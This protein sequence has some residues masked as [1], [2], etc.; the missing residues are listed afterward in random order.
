MENLKT[1]LWTWASLGRYIWN[2]KSSPQH[3]SIINFGRARCGLVAMQTRTQTPADY[4]LCIFPLSAET[5]EAQAST[6]EGYR[7]G[8]L[9]PAWTGVFHH[10]W[11]R[12]GQFAFWMHSHMRWCNITLPALFSSNREADIPR[13]VVVAGPAMNDTQR[14]SFIPVWPAVRETC[15]WRFNTFMVTNAI[16][17]FLQPRVCQQTLPSLIKY[18]SAEQPPVSPQRPNSF[19]NFH[20]HR[21]N[22]KLFCLL[23]Y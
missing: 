22:V 2:P 23:T 20:T 13:R 14:S 21:S 12:G 11:M 1:L 18:S 10:I 5:R 19:L 9:G 17:C 7:K 8:S 3:S 15:C 16:I 6:F 4:N